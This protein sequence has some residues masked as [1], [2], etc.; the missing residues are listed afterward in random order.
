MTVFCAHRQEPNWQPENG[1]ARHVVAVEGTTYWVETDGPP[2]EI[3]ELRRVVGL[4][5]NPG[6]PPADRD[7]MLAAMASEIDTLKAAI[8]K[9]RDGYL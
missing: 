4:D 9:L 3:G 7:A 2:P 1:R 8:A 6:P 5:P